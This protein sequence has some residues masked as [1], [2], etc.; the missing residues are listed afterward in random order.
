MPGID[1]RYPSVL[2]DAQQVIISG[3]QVLHAA[4]GSA[5]EQM[6]VVRVPADTRRRF[7][8]EK[9]RLT[10]QELQESLSVRR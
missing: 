1:D 9:D 8:G 2:S 4:G 10:P 7:D 6:V 5:A 3:D